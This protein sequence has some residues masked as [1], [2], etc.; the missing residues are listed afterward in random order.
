[1]CLAFWLVGNPFAAS[2]QEVF[3]AHKDY[4]A[5]IL[6]SRFERISFDRFFKHNDKFKS[7]KHGFKG[8]TTRKKMR[9]SETIL[10]KIFGN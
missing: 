10:E 2:L 1:M 7:D 6:V 9:K 3:F 5:L 8:E 4:Q